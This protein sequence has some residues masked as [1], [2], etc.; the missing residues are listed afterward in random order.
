MKRNVKQHVKGTGAWLHGACPNEDC[1]SSDAFA[2]REDEPRGY[3][4]SCGETNNVDGEGTPGRGPHS[5]KKEQMSTRRVRPEDMISFEDIEE[6][7]SASIVDRKIRKNICEHYGVKV[8]HE[9]HFYP[10]TRR[11]K[12]VAYKRRKLPKTFST[13]GDWKGVDQLFGQAQAMPGRKLFITEGECDAMALQQ[14]M[15]EKYQRFYP[16][17]SLP[18]ASPRAII[19]KN[20]DWIRS[21]NEVVLCLDNDEAGQEALADIAKIVGYDRAKVPASYGEKDFCDLWLAKG[22]QAVRSA[23]FE[24]QPYRPDGFVTGEKLWEAYKKK[25]EVIAVPYPPC[26]PEVNDKLQGMRRGEVVLL[27]SGTGCFQKGTEVL[28]KEGGRKTVEDVVVGDQL[29]GDDGTTRKVQ[30]LYRGQEEMAKITL[31][32]GSS[33]VCN[34]SHILSLVRSGYEYRWG[35]KEGDVVDVS[36]AEYLSWSPKKKH[37]FKSF[38][39]EGVDYPHRKLPIHP[40]ILGVWLGDGYSAGARFSAES[41]SIAMLD[42]MRQLGL[43]LKKDSTKF[44][45][46]SPGGFLQK[47]RKQN[48]VNNKHIPEEYLCS[49]RSQRLQLLAGLLD[50]DGCYNAEK[51]GYEFSQKK[52]HI[53]L[54]VKSLAESLGYAC[55]LGKQKNNPFG[56]CYRLWISGGKIDQIPC[57]LERKQARLRMQI[58]KSN[59]YSF[60]IETLPIDNFYGFEVDGNGRFLLGNHI[61]THNSGKST[62]VKEIILELGE[63]IE[64]IEEGVGKIALM[65]LEESPGDTTEK[66]IGMHLKTNM[67]KYGI[68]E[69]AEREAFEYIFGDDRIIVADHQGSIADDSILDR[70]EYMILSGCT[71]L[72]LDHITIAVSEGDSDGKTGNEA[73][74][75]LMSGLL[76][77][78]KKHNVWIGVVSHLRKGKPGAVP[79][80]Q[81]RLPSMD[82]IKGS[83]A[84]KQVSFDILAFA[85]DMTAEDPRIR[86]TV[87]LRVLKAR[88]TGDT[89]DAGAMFY[90]GDTTRME[91]STLDFDDINE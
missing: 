82:D 5:H 76:K 63:Y 87:K 46:G 2:W 28:L 88:E 84:I 48:L 22:G 34:T 21:Y 39:S 59:R 30:R 25:Q 20:R 11:G 86:N 12:V 64:N 4:F 72:F 42:K 24:V 50:T 8:T 90:N 31:R 52:E 51:N 85:R 19:L 32:D 56:N 15:F 83:G 77:L 10:Y 80:E 35:T 69:D 57:A 73:V 61:V 36:V 43:N 41:S 44:A 91:A 60:S 38:K 70:L 14:A 54:A 62:I 9:D 16:I 47:L 17:V 65:F 29:I 23:A 33:F 45:W 75:A 3:C 1:G 37:L 74:D 40:Y 89:G 79:F 81:G 18:S 49:S 27:T 55:S 66:F 13:V 71:H 58:K 68:E 78:V 7:D 53:V 26:M 67:R 6:F